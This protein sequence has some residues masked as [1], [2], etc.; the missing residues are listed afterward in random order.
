MS[1]VALFERV[2]VLKLHQDIS[3]TNKNKPWYINC[4]EIMKMRQK[5]KSKNSRT[6]TKGS[7]TCLVKLPPSPDVNGVLGLSHGFCGPWADGC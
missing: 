1:K 5:P 7:A 3:L 2:W 6:D 4:K